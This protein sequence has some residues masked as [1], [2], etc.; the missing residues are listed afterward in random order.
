MDGINASKRVTRPTEVMSNGGTNGKM[1]S[2]D[3]RWP[4]CGAQNISGSIKPI[5]CL[6]KDAIYKYLRIRNSSSMAMINFC[7][8][9]TGIR[10]WI[11]QM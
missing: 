10:R 11:W 8:L 5:L 1:D 3:M 4:G 7:N 6:V 2:P 9:G